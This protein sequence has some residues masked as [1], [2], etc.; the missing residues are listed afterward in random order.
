M[1]RWSE[2]V[3]GNWREFFKPDNCKTTKLKIQSTNCGCKTTV[4]N[5]SNSESKTLYHIADKLPSK[6]KD[7]KDILDIID[8]INESV[9]SD[10]HVL[11]SFNV[12]NM[13]SNI[14]NKSS[15]E[16]VMDVLYDNSLNLD[17]TQC[18]ADTLEICLI[19]NNSKFKHQHF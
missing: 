8:S 13:F 18:I 9:L 3:N 15:L 16:S 19:F 5:L 14:D 10:N 4:K 17:S 2:K 6:I 12:V 11:G 7:T 1:E